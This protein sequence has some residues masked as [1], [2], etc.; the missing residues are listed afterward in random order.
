MRRVE[1]EVDFTWCYH[2]DCLPRLSR[3]LLCCS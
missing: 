3:V 2:A 1:R